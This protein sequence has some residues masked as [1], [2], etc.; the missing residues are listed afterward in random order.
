MD[1]WRGGACR[2]GLPLPHRN[3]E[4]QMA[5]GSSGT[6]SDYWPGF[7]DALTNVVIAM[8]FVIV[9][10]AIALSFALQMVAKRMSD[11][12]AQLEQQNQASAT[13]LAR[14]QESGQRA[15]GAAGPAAPAAAPDPRFQSTVIPV[16]SVV[17]VDDPASPSHLLIRLRSV[18]DQIRLDYAPTAMMLNA[19]AIQ[20]LDD[21]VAGYIETLAR[22]DQN[23]RLQLLAQGPKMYLSENQHAAYVRVMDVRNQLLNK[24]VRGDQIDP[25]VDLDAP[26]DHPLVYVR[27]VAR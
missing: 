8:V 2:F 11:R 22:S 24:G 20:Q 12:V 9:V 7:V 21:A 27:I 14:A 13:A 23:L 25:H 10:L 4:A 17:K 19:A 15:R 26:A 18:R 6:S 3:R 1:T 16:E 5:G